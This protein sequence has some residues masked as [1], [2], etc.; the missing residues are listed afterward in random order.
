MITSNRFWQITG[1]AIALSA[2][3]SACSPASQSSKPPAATPI[4]AASPPAMDHKGMD[5]KGM[6]SK[7]MDSKGM[8]S[9]GMDSKGMDSKGMDSKGMDHKGMDHKGMDHSMD[10]GPADADY[11][12]RFIDAM[13]P[14]HEGALIMAKDLAQKSQRPEL[15]KLAK[16]IIRAQTQEIAQMKQWRTAW[17]PQA[18]STP[19]A[20]HA[21]MKHMM[22][23]KP[24]QVS[25]MRMDLDLGKADRQYD[26]R[27]LQAMVPHHQ[28][29]V[30]MAQDLAQKT[31]RPE[32]Q[33][34]SQNILTSQQAE[35]DQMQ[36][37][38]KSWY[39]K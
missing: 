31:K 26:L 3:V 22:A 15:Q 4:A 32:L 36:A 30:V 24:E 34:L 37:W 6:D 5:H 9:K 27:F 12:L 17:Y 23:M 18:P 28:A 21:E 35:I 38:Q 33:K 7:G 2:V 11:D 25:A 10:L 8:D 13:I 1:G 29:A 19:M 16:D 39:G 20:W 14:H